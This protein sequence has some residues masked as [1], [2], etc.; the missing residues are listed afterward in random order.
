MSETAP[1]IELLGIG[2]YNHGNESLHGVVRPGKFT[3]FP[4]PM[5]LGATFNPELV[6]TMA[7]CISDES[8]ARYNELGRTCNA[9][10]GSLFG[11][12]YNGLLTFWSPT[13]NMARDPRWG[14]TGETFRGKYVAD[15]PYGR[16]F[17]AWI[18]GRP[19]G[20]ISEGGGR[21]RSIMPRTTRSIIGSLAMRS[22]R[23][24]RCGSII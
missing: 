15:F 7:D 11:G 9:D 1:A 13:V 4:R 21:R 10:D 12:K 5:G 22:F 16:G 18:T 3:V 2:N 19:V 6:Q 8:R 17:H 24:A 14:R 20:E 23:N